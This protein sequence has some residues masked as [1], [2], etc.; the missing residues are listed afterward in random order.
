[1]QS[2]N[3]FNV[4]KL[5]LNDIQPNSKQ[6]SASKNNKKQKLITNVAEENSKSFEYLKHKRPK[7]KKPEKASKSTEKTKA[8]KAENKKPAKKQLNKK[9]NKAI[10][11]E[12]KSLNSID[13]SYINL[14]DT[15]INEIQNC[16]NYANMEIDE[17]NSAPASIKDHVIV[18]P[19]KRGRPK[20]VQAEEKKP[21]ISNKKNQSKIKQ[22][23]TENNK[24]PFNN[25]NKQK[26][27]K[28]KTNSLAEKAI[29]SRKFLKPQ[30]IKDK[31]RFPSSKR[32][33]N[34][35][36]IK[37][38]FD[39][40]NSEK[41]SLTNKN[42][43]QKVPNLHE[44]SENPFS[45]FTTFTEN[46]SK[47][48]PEIGKMVKILKIVKKE[49]SDF[50]EDTDEDNFSPPGCFDYDVPLRIDK[51]TLDETNAVFVVLKWKPRYDGS[52]PRKSIFP[53]VEI[54]EKCPSLLNNYLMDKLANGSISLK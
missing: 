41:T 31:Y 35:I 50:K 20:K 27:N 39:N 7:S 44:N 12:P 32:D 3:I 52:I 43:K 29:L 18:T 1:M 49:N 54:Q 5:S 24:K 53:A 26:E 46:S 42:A 9:A 6:E 15:T 23:F 36:S 11:I 19:K 4:Q 34:N 16:F 21:P 45:N 17:I 10:K 48:I 8:K 47:N 28:N 14:C 13:C 22:F 25:S 51:F 2:K 33:S 40:K 37:V 30:D 38:E